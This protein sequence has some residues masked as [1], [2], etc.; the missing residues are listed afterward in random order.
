MTNNGTIVNLPAALVPSDFVQAAVTEF[1]GEYH[2]RV[3]LS[4]LK[5]TVENADPATTLDN[6]ITNATIGINKQVTD[7]VTAD[8]N[9][10]ATVEVYSELNGITNNQQANLNGDFYGNVPVSYQCDVTFHW[11]TV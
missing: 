11:R 4:V 5:S 10:A 9:G 1:E 7:L 2:R 3:T 8:S 6:I